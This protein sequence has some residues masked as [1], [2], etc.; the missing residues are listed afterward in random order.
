[1]DFQE[2]NENTSVL[3][4]LAVRDINISGLYHLEMMRIV[5]PC[6]S[7][8]KAD[9]EEL[10]REHFLSSHSKGDNGRYCVGLS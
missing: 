7:F 9:G 5:D 3:C 4:S 8:T 6:S 1:M 2:I 10:A